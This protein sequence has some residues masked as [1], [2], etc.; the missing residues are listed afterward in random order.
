MRCISFRSVLRFCLIPRPS[1]RATQRDTASSSFPKQDDKACEQHSCIL[2]FRVW[3]QQI[4]NYWWI[5]KMIPKWYCERVNIFLVWINFCFSGVG[6]WLGLWAALYHRFSVSLV[7][8]RPS[9][10]QW[11]AATIPRSKYLIRTDSYKY[12][13]TKHKISVCCNISIKYQAKCY[14]TNT[15]GYG[16]ITDLREILGIVRC[17]LKFK[18]LIKP[19]IYKT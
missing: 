5:S 9:S 11:R 12:F 7:S 18:Y 15:R 13:D 10:A 17:H 4:F 2:L 19:K 6:N 1:Q 3:I 14:W 16:K 8:I